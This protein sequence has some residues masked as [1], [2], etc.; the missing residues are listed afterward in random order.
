[1]FLNF[2]KLRKVDKSN[3]EFKDKLL[4]FLHD[5]NQ[6]A[7]EL[8]LVAKKYDLHFI[9]YIANDF[10]SSVKEFYKNIN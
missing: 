8:N 3:P 4:W 2:F 1:M 7:E 5:I 9:E 6:K 10:K